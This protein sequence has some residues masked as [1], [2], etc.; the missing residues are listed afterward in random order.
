MYKIYNQAVA[1]EPEVHE[2]V[3]DDEPMEAEYTFAHEGTTHTSMSPII[4]LPEENDP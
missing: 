1:V 2:F 4:S 3:Q